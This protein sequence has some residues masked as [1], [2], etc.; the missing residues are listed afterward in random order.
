MAS[1]PLLLALDQ[2]TTSTRAILFDTSGTPLRTAQRELR[3]IYPAAGWVEHDPEE[4]WE[5]SVQV[6]ARGRR[7]LPAGRHRHHQ[8]ARDD[9]A[10]G[11]RERR[12]P[13][14]RHRLAGPAHG[15]RVRS[16][17]RGRAGSRS[18][19]TRSGLLIDP[20]FSA[21]K[22]AWLLDTLPGARERSDLAFGTVDSFLVWRL[23]GGR[24]HATDA[25]N[26]ARTNLF[27]IRS[28]RLEPGASRAL[29]RARV[30]AAGGARQR[31]RLRH[32]GHPGRARAGRWHGRRSAGGDAGPGL[33]RRP[34]TSRAPT[35]PAAS[36]W[37]TRAPSRSPR[38]TGC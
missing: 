33:P 38:A 34:A 19:P 21:T 10:L 30:G 16:A 29:R 3:Q 15:G 23:T 18:S 24:V 22:L 14:Q 36:C 25:T 37:P 5:A 6:L 1:G 8:P 12:L 28:L 31:G 7:R 17:S 35:A 11:P 20:Y 32:H 27:D 13:A 4:I 9:A 2:G 26:A